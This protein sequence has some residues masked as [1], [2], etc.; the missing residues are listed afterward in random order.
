MYGIPT[1]PPEPPLP[2]RFPRSLTA[3]AGMI[4]LVAACGGGTATPPGGSPDSSAGT[5][6]PSTGAAAGS[7]SGDSA[8]SPAER[9]V[10]A[11]DQMATGYTFDSTLTVGGKVATHATGRWAGGSSEVV[12]ESGGISITYRAIPPLAWVLKPGADWVL[13]DGA[14]PSGDP[15]DALSQPTATSASSEDA[16]GLHLVGTYTAADLGVTGPGS[17]PVTLLVAPD[18]SITA[19]YTADATSGSATSVVVLRPAAS[20]EPIVAPSPSAKPS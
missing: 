2:P 16:A 9:L 17:V 11:F 14:I 13:V 1:R 5:A 12:I 8:V 4:L 20:P 19:T 7:S 6:G 15:L 10:V 18:G 3:L